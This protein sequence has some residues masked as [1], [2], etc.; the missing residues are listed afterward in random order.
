MKIFSQQLYAQCIYNFFHFS[1]QDQIFLF[2]NHDIFIKMMRVIMSFIL[3][4]FINSCRRTTELFPI[5]L[6]YIQCIM[7]IF[8]ILEIECDQWHFTTCKIIHNKLF[9]FMVFSKFKSSLIQCL[10]S[11]LRENLF[12]LGVILFPILKYL[13]GKLQGFLFIGE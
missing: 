2:L 3:S 12:F 11:E 7:S 13:E 4:W 9:V 8:Y 5:Y 6:R 1:I 10:L